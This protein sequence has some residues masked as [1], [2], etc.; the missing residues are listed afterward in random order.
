MELTALS[1]TFC[2]LRVRGDP[3]RAM[4]KAGFRTVPGEPPRARVGIER[5]LRLQVASGRRNQKWEGLPLGARSG[6]S[7]TGGKKWQSY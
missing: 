7:R 6:R 5:S 3:F 2:H 4:R 1:A